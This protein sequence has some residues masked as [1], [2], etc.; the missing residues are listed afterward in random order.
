[1]C[2][3]SAFAQTPPAFSQIIV[4][5]DSLSDT[6]NV[7]DRTGSASGGVVDYPSHTFNYANGSFTNDDQTDPSTSLH[8][9][10]WHEQ[11]AQG[12]LG[13]PVATYSLGGGLNYAFGGGTTNDG[14]HEEVAVSTPFGDV[15]ITVDDMGKQMDDYLASHVVDPSALY[16]VW[17]GGNDLRN[18]DSP[19]NV[20]TTAAR[21]TALA[22]RLANAG[23]QYIMVPNVPPLGDI[24]RY[25]TDPDR[26]TTLNF[27]SANYRQ[28]LNADLDALLGSLAPQ[29]IAPTIYRPDTW[30][31][32]IRIFSDPSRYGFIFTADG[33]QGNDVNPDVVLF[34]DDVHPTTA[35]HHEIARAAFETITTPPA[36]LSKALNIATRVFVDTGERVPIAGFIVTGDVAKRVLIRGIGPS[37]ATNGVPNPLADPTLTLFDDKGGTLMMN[38]NWR[39]SQEPEIAATGIPPQNDLESAIIANL[40]PGHYTTALTG[41]SETTGN[42]LIEVYDLEAETGSTLA[43]LSTRGFV[44][45]GDN[46]MIGS[47]IVGSGDSAIIVLRAIG[48]SLANSGIA[49]PLLDP[50][51]ELHDGNGA[52]LAFNDDWR[53]PQLQA[54]YATL[55]PPTDDRESAIVAP[56]LA[57][58]NYTAI[59]RGK[60][61]TTGVALVEAY[62][63][64]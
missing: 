54:V 45:N 18:D 38:N 6:G 41:V 64:P 33:A 3:L 23:A 37:L 30:T 35:G 62:R 34:W 61:D 51:I 47:L 8:L 22:G 46:V 43:N 39:D 60:A 12:F 21:A 20:T 1:L 53:S 16:V 29:G 11:L 56:F 26:V 4:F 57:A 10:V 2:V 14:T 27:A 55:L 7:R 49:N 52:T 59:V 5:G 44:G 58:G 17:G 48:P 28:E 19:G 25:L 9:G 40:P 13:L 32:T 36:P 31:N 24:P 42:G 50:T 15:T 63:I